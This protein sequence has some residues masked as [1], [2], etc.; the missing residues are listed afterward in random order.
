[1]STHYWGPDVVDLVLYTKPSVSFVDDSQADMSLMGC[2]ASEP[3][4]TTVTVVQSVGIPG[5]GAYI[6]IFPAIIRAFPFP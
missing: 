2:S 5:Y 4:P 1:M 3:I 6:Q